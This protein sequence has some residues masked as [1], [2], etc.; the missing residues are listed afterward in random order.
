[1]CVHACVH[2]C[3]WV[4]VSSSTCMSRSE[5]S[6]QKSVISF[7]HCVCP[8]GQTQIIMLVSKHTYSLSHLTRPVIFFPS[9][10]LFFLE[11]IACIPNSTC[12]KDNLE[13]IPLLPSKSWD[14]RCAWSPLVQVVLGI[15]SRAS[16]TIGKHP[17]NLDISSDSLIPFYR[18]G[19]TMQS[20]L[21]LNSLTLVNFKFMILLSQS[22]K[23]LEV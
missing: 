19:F 5:D 21:A 17:I 14:Y 11:R 23:C 2:T 10:L 13:L 20:W 8:R 4:H 3:A 22:L 6:L 18:Q 7:I 9:F 16:C 1:M 12:T 15:K